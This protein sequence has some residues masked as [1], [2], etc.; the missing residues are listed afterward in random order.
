VG[1]APEAKVAAPTAAVCFRKVRRF[2][3][4]SSGS[5]SSSKGLVPS[6]PG[7]ALPPAGPAQRSALLFVLIGVAVVDVVD[8]PLDEAGAG[9]QVGM[10]EE[11]LSPLG[12]ADGATAVPPTH[13]VDHRDHGARL[14][15]VVR[16]PAVPE[17][18]VADQHAA[19]P[20]RRLD[21]R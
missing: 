2:I 12:E 19:C 8:R 1:A 5:L 14:I 21:W 4:S 17:P 20:H 15:G 6:S 9:P 7:A 16:H 11:R 18:D 3:T 13:P 10:L